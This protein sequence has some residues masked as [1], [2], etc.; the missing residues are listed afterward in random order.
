MKKIKYYN[1][2]L[3]SNQDDIMTIF[4]YLE[5]KKDISKELLLKNIDS[6]NIEINNFILLEKMIIKGFDWNHRHNFERMKIVVDNSNVNHIISGAKKPKLIFGNGEI[7]QINGLTPLHINA[8]V[9]ITKSF[10]KEMLKLLTNAGANWVVIDENGKSILDYTKNIELY[11]EYE[12]YEIALKGI[13][14]LKTASKFNL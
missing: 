13:K 10:E 14:K 3:E 11:Q 4:K 1:K 12:E 9:A 7:Y 5:L 6:F 8:I 2:F